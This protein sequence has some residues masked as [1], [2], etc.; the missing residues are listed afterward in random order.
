[1]SADHGF[2][3]SSFLSASRH[4]EFQHR[5]MSAETWAQIIVKYACI[6]NIELQFNGIDL[7]RCLNT[8]KMNNLR[9]ATD[10]DASKVTSDHIGIF[11]DN[12][13]RHGQPSKKYYYY[14]TPKGESP[15]K[16]ENK[17]WYECV[18]DASDLLLSTIVITHSNSITTPSIVQAIANQ[19]QCTLYPHLNK[20]RKLE[21]ALALQT[22]V[23]QPPEESNASVRNS[24]SMLILVTPIANPEI[25]SPMLSP[26]SNPE[27]ATPMRTDSRSITPNNSIPTAPHGLTP[28]M[29]LENQNIWWESPEARKLFNAH[30]DESNI[31]GILRQIDIL[32]KF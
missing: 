1:M 20:K 28:T 13:R 31:A 21:E 3:V 27:F 12:Y 29:Q 6:S 2:I 15:I 11:R 22:S 7:N 23:A 30:K 5:W 25:P 19:D 4:E 17:H 9:D 14:A 24:I 32:K 8:K 26:M 10:V 16:L 18:S